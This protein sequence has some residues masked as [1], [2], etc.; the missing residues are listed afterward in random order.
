LMLLTSKGLP[1]TAGTAI[2]VHMCGYKTV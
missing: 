2:V 1:S